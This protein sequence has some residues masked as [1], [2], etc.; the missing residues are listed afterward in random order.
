[1]KK[2]LSFILFATLLVSKISASEPS[3]E[4]AKPLSQLQQEF[5]NLRFGMFIHFNIPTVSGHD[6][7]DPNQSLKVFN[8]QKL[9]CDQ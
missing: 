3:I 9:D 1:M 4:V 8:P 5:L 6:W 2:L 7:P